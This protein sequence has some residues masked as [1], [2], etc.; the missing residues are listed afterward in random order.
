MHRA[1]ATDTNRGGLPTDSGDSVVTIDQVPRWSDLECGYLY[2]HED[3]ASPNAY[4]LDPLASTA[5][6]E[7]SGNGMHARFPMN[8]EINS[9]IYLWKGDPWNLEVDA[10]VNST[11][12]VIVGM[13]WHSYCCCCW[14][15][16]FVTLEL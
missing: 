4:F 10:V 7:N 13:S 9:K 8:L 16:T 11:N 5:E 3:P 14:R 6:G 1:G 15:S 12:E 2:E